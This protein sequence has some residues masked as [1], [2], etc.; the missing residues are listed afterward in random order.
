MPLQFRMCTINL[1][2]YYKVEQR[3]TSISH[4]KWISSLQFLSLKSQD[5]NIHLFNFIII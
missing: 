2:N 4:V 5:T 1:L 3:N